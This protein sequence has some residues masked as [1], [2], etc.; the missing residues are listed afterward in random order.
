MARGTLAAEGLES[1]RPFVQFDQVS[2]AERLF[3]GTRG[4]H[5][6]YC[7]PHL[8]NRCGVCNRYCG[9]TVCVCVGRVCVCVCGSCVCVDCTLHARVRL[10]GLHSPRHMD[11]L[12]ATRSEM[13]LERQKVVAF[14]MVFACLLSSSHFWTLVTSVN[15]V[16]SFQRDFS[17]HCFHSIP[18]AL[19]SNDVN[20][21]DPCSSLL[22]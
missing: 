3:S 7:H 21:I 4:T 1:P 15:G 11:A 12:M 2:F 19:V 17:F 13:F 14:A 10:V 8:W 16:E 9:A 22:P 6:D 18:E 5:R 20:K